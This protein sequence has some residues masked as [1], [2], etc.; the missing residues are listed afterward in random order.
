M[1]KAMVLAV[2]LAVFYGSIFGEELQQYAQ[3]EGAGISEEVWFMKIPEVVT[4]SKAKE[5]IN[6]APAIVYVVT[7]EEIKLSGARSVAEILKRVPGMRISVRET[8]LLG[9]RGFTSDQNDK[10]LFLI[11]GTPI[12]N[13]MQDGVY[14]FIDIPNL[15]MVEKIEVVKGPASTLWGSDATFGIVNIITKKRAGC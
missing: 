1:K 11:D 10:F 3:A 13:I 7:R 15:N 8:S 14:N 4:A 5:T 2:V 12:T 9:S 6:K